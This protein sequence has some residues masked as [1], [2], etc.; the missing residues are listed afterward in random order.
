MT[1][2]AHRTGAKHASLTMAANF[3][4]VAYDCVIDQKNKNNNS[5]D[6]FDDCDDRKAKTF[7]LFGKRKHSDIANE[8]LAHENLKKMPMRHVTE[9][10]GSSEWFKSRLFSFAS[11]SADI[12]FALK[13]RNT[14]EINPTCISNH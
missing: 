7:R 9:K 6:E 3:D 12:Q 5:S 10:Q 14:T 2:Y 1:A 8:S 11:S 13:Y 4:G